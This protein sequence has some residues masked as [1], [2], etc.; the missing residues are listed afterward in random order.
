MTLYKM[1]RKEHALKSLRERRLKIARLADQNDPFEMLPFDMSN[2]LQRIAALSVLERTNGTVGVVCFSRSWSN[3]VIWAHYAD[4]HRGLCLGFEVP[5]DLVIPI[6][7]ANRRDLFPDI[8]NMD[9]PM[10]FKTM[11]RVL[12]T[13]FADWRYEDEVRLSVHLDH[14]TSENGLYFVDWGDTLRL[15]E[16][17]VGMRSSTCRREL[18]R[19]LVGY[20]HPVQFIKAQA[21]LTSFAVDRS[22]DAVRNHDEL[23]WFLL[24]GT[25]MHPVEF[26]V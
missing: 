10:L 1:L 15:A 19:A 17:I 23:T 26:V 11:D 21:S 8:L 20:E 4:Q 6:T 2:P 25:T 18:E 13:K 3:P 5:D 16:V 22:P 14:D 12:Y 9:E 7:Y 24:K